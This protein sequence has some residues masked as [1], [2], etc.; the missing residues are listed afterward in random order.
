MENIEQ[1]YLNEKNRSD[2]PEDL[3]GKFLFRLI[4]LQNANNQGLN[5]LN[6]RQYARN[7]EIKRCLNAGLKNDSVKANLLAEIKKSIDGKEIDLSQIETALSQISSSNTAL[8]EPLK[9]IVLHYPQITAGLA[10]IA[11]LVAKNKPQNKD[12]VTSQEKV[13]KEIGKLLIELTKEVK[14]KKFPEELKI[15][16]PVEISQP[17][18]YKPFTFSWEPLEK[19]LEKLKNH[20]FSVK[21]ENQLKL[22]ENFLKNL[23]NE[24][25]KKVSSV[26]AEELPKIR[27]RGG[28]S[29]VNTSELA[30]EVKQTE[31]ITSL[32]A[33]AEALG[34]VGAGASNLISGRKVI[35]VTGTPIALGSAACKT[36][37]IN[38]LTTNTDV[39]VIGDNTVVYD[40]AT[41][42]GKVLYPGDTLT[43]SIDNLSKIFQNGLI[44]NGVTFSYLT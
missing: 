30:K 33:I 25:A 3:I 6:D 11:E 43:I 5:G 15:S 38:A 21:V 32:N 2:S 13:A 34:S 16:G 14:N 19:L 4:Q 26:L 22:D 28:G 17:K 29:G 10:K 36:V 18:W 39:I 23:P 35:A 41:R 20:K 27:I 12:V 1:Q 8:G 42:T 7:E 24:I 44:N 37:F 9:Q 40:E 31:M